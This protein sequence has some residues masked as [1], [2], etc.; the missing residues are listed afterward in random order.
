MAVMLWFVRDKPLF[1]SGA[2]VENPTCN[3]E[4][5]S[6]VV[7]N[8]VEKVRKSLKTQVNGAE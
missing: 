5:R 8:Y 1:R 7:N 4:K 3:V 2:R 6:L